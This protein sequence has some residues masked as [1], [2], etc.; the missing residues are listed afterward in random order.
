MSLGQ[1]LPQRII[2]IIIIILA[3]EFHKIRKVFRMG[4]KLF[5]CQEGPCWVVVV[6]VIIML[7]D[8]WAFTSCRLVNL[9]V[10]T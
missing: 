3:S 1:T 2:I 10:S 4:E 5:V 6:I 9:H 7:F 8:I